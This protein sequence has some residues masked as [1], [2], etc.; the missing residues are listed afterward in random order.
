MLFANLTIFIFISLS[1]LHSEQTKLN[2]VL[3]VLSAIG[4]SVA[5]NTALMD[6]RS[7]NIYFFYWKFKVYGYTSPSFF[8]LV[9]KGDNFC[10]FL[11]AYLEKEMSTKLGLL[12]K[13]KNCSHWSK[14]FLL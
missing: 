9:F 4:L 6:N 2:G 11:F 7:F 8:C 1:Q 10:N 12:L 13:E 3:A 14:F 5:D